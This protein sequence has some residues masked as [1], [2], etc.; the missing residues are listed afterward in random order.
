LARGSGLS[1]SAFAGLTCIF[2]IIAFAGGLGSIHPNL[3]LVGG[4]GAIALC[5]VFGLIPLWLAILMFALI[6]AG[7]IFIRGRF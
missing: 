2:L 1:V 7:F 4:T 6:V 3:G 5:F